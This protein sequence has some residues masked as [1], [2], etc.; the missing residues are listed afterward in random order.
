MNILILLDFYTCT[1]SPLKILRYSNTVE[2]QVNIR[3]NEST[4]FVKQLYLN[5]EE[6]GIGS[7]GTFDGIE[8][9]VDI[10]EL[11]KKLTKKLELKDL[12]MLTFFI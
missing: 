3:D 9:I 7:E 12:E 10:K 1:N 8:V 5:E 6:V 11:Y 4:Y 2:G